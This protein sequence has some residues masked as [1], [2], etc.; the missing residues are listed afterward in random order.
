MIIAN[1]TI[2]FFIS[3]AF[4]YFYNEIIVAVDR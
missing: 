1:N 2:W 3:E 4:M